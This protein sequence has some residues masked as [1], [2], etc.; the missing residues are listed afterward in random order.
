MDKYEEIRKLGAGSFGVA[1]LVKRRGDGILVVAKRMRLCGMSQKE[2]EDALNE[3]RC[4]SKIRHA[5]VT[6]YHE[7]L[8]EKGLLNIIMEY[9]PNG[10]L[11]LR[12][13]KQRM[14]TPTPFTDDQVMRWVVQL[15]VALDFI[16]EECRILHRDIKPPNIFLGC[17]DVVKLGDLGIAKTLDKS[18]EMAHTFVGTPFYMSPEICRNEEYGFKSDMWASGCVIYELISL[19]RPFDAANLPALVLRIVS[20]ESRGLPPTSAGCKQLHT[21]VTSGL[22]RKDAISRPSARQLL[23]SNWIR[24]CPPSVLHQQQQQKQQQRRQRQRPRLPVT[25]AAWGCERLREA[26]SRQSRGSRGTG[27]RT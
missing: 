6:L 5:C 20:A 19:S 9:A 1:L 14:P 15:L 24:K 17:D 11:A 12:I 7:S 22:L 26:N 27:S 18:L 21:S 8:L 10:D 3:V 16:H 4:L 2:R 13:R 23:D 25:R